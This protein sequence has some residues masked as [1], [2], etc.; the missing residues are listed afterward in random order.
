MLIRVRLFAAL[1]DLA[2]SSEVD[3]DAE[4]VGDVLEVLAERFGARFDAI[5]RAGS[6]VVDGERATADTRVRDAAEVAL[7]PPVSGGAHAE[8]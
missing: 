7:L 1:R 5:A 3:V 2:G 4:T 6:T 8:A